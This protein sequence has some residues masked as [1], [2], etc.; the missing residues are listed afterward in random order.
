MKTPAQRQAD[1]RARLK[2]YD[3]V[4]VRGLFLPPEFHP[5][6]RRYAASIAPID[7]PISSGRGKKPLPDLVVSRGSATHIDEATMP[8]QAAAPAQPF[9]PIVHVRGLWTQTPRPRALKNR[10]V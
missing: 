9:Q 2:A 3:L 7:H 5:A 4:E 6:L 10:K 8:R 1:R